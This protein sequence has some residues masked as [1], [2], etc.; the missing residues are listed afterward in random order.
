LFFVVAVGR[1]DRAHY[2]AKAMELI[3]RRRTLAPAA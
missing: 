2:A 1:P 3:G